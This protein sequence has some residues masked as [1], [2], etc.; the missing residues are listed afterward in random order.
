[1]GYTFET[2]KAL[3]DIKQRNKIE[4]ENLRHENAMKE[5]KAAHGESFKTDA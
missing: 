4:F 2:S 3:E 1:M 5:I